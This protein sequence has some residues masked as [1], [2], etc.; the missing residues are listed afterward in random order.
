MRRLQIEVPLSHLVASGRNP[1][2]VKPERQSHRRLVALIR[3][4]GLLQPLVVRPM[5]DKPKHYQ[6]IAGNRRLAALKEIHRGDG[7]PKIPCVRCDVDTPT[8]DAL[9]LGE[10]F[11][12]EPMHPLDEADAFAKLAS[13][14]GKDA[15]TIAA[16]FGVSE[17]Y[18]RQRMKLSVLAE[19]IRKA[20]RDGAIDTGIAEAFS[21][22]P[23]DRQLEIWKELGGR[24]SH[25]E[26]VRRVIAS[27][28]I[29]AS[30]ASF[31][32]S[33][34]PES[35]IS[36]DLFSERILIE[37]QAFMAAQTHAISLQRQTMIE[38][39]WSEV[40]FGKREEVQDR[41]YS[42]ETLPQEFDQKTEAKLA[43]IALEQQ[44]LET[45]SESLEE[46]STK[47]ERLQTRMEEL[48]QEEQEIVQN[49][50]VCYSE[51]TKSLATAFLT[52]DPDGRTHVEY[53]VPRKRH[54]V[55]GE[56][57]SGNAGDEPKV[58]TSDDL[59]DRQ[60]AITFT[61]QAL[62]V[63]EA[64]LKNDSARRR[65]LALILHEKVHGEGLSIRLDVNHTT[66]FASREEG[67]ASSAFESIQAKRGKCDPF[68]ESHL[69]E[70]HEGFV[71]LE[72][73]SKS[74]LEA[75][76]DLLIVECVTAQLHRPTQLVRLLYDQLKV[77]IRAYWKPDAIW[78]SSYQ[79]I[80]LAQLLTELTHPQNPVGP[81]RKKTELVE[82][83]AQL[84]SDAAEGTLE[85]KPLEKRL[86]Q[87]LPPNLRT[88][89][90]DE[91]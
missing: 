36:Q 65:V 62:V 39:G 33:T 8:A 3:S 5:K 91:S 55:N 51:E 71:Q 41:L 17:H 60:K 46:G 70:D 32:V 42:M 6:V 44:K 14:D 2:R 81:N 50:P 1:R 30:L 16:V 66:L 53:R 84:F 28:W 83:L 31:D 79:K 22:V 29:D 12:R 47:M 35:A 18:I 86:N 13:S 85:D 15:R 56:N 68:R 88:S 27:A 40:V 54:G 38:D 25:A 64:L 52:M 7:D 87:W 9:S 76:I 69:I 45:R 37:R 48:E 21:A 58:P 24:P 11:G 74:R 49:A 19:P 10:N 78:L 59:S 73:L 90:K 72:K 34:L 20:Y 26:Q 67:F 61:H 89:V 75:L 80:Q 57:G 77:N 63:R 82:I 4:H 23:E 43:A